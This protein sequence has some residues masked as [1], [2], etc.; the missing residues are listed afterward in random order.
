MARHRA[1]SP[2]GAT[3]GLNRKVATT[4]RASGQRNEAGVRASDVRQVLAAM[5]TGGTPTPDSHGE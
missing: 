4:V 5:L 3:A 2:E 1:T